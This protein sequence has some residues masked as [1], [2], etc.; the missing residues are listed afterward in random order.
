MYLNKVH[1]EHLYVVEITILLLI[2]RMYTLIFFKEFIFHNNLAVS[3]DNSLSKKVSL[4]QICHTIIFSCIDHIIMSKHVINIITDNFLLSDPCNHYIYN[5]VYMSIS[6]TELYRKT[7]INLTCIWS[8]ATSKQ[9]EQYQVCLNN[10][11]RA[12][13]QM[14]SAYVC[15]DVHCTRMEHRNEIDL[16]CNCIIESCV[17]SGLHCILLTMFSCRDMPGCTEQVEP[18]WNQLLLWHWM[19]WCELGK[20]NKGIVYD[21]MK[22]ARHKYH[23]TTTNPTTESACHKP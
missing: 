4:M 1:G 3:W 9:K 7:Q 13:A 17:A 22:S 6:V 18:E 11:L 14:I 19:G 16:L 20:H 10:E 15:T 8:K 12:I 5:I 2:D 23:L 21:V